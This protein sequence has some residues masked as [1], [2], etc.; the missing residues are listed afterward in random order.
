MARA[1]AQRS[2]V[3][4]RGMTKAPSLRPAGHG[5]RQTQWRAQQHKRSAVLRREAAQAPSLRPAGHGGSAFVSSFQSHLGDEALWG[6]SA[7]AR[8]E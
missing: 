6:P 7:P 3:L 5:G 8:D 1:A 4:R 2:A